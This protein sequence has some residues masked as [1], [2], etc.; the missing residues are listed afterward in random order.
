[1]IYLHIYTNTYIY[2]YRLEVGLYISAVDIHTIYTFIFV[3]WMYD[4][5]YIC[6]A[7]THDIYIYTGS[8]V[9]NCSDQLVLLQ[10]SLQQL[11]VILVDDQQI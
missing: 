11:H 2:I 1:M 3:D 8:M 6:C 7:Y 4:C 10:P 9:C 5:T